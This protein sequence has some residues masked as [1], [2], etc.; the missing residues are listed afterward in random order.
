MTA[1]G[2]RKSTG[3]NFGFGF[4]TFRFPHFPRAPIPFPNHPATAR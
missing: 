1:N 3:S 2:D 4:S